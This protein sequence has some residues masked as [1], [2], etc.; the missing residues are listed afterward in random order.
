[1]KSKEKIVRDV[2]FRLVNSADYRIVIIEDINIKFLQ[3][4]IDFFKKIIAA[5]LKNKD[6]T[7]DWYKKELIK[8]DLSKEEIALHAGL[9]MKTI[10]NMYN[11]TEKQVVIDAS[12]EHYDI[13]YEKI[14]SLVKDKNDVTITL[15]IK[16]KGV[17]VDLNISESLIVINTLAVKRSSLRGGSWSA[18]GKAV[19][20][21]LMKVLC[22]LFEV[23]KKHFKQ[24]SLP[25]SMREVDFYLIGQKPSDKYRCEVKLMGKG[26][27]ESAD[28][29][30]ARNTKVFV[31]D[32]LSDL[33]KKQL[34]Q[35][36]VEWVCLRD[37]N[38]YKRFETVLKNLEIPYKSIKGDISDSLNKA[39]DK[40]GIRS[41]GK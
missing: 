25:K 22:L 7:V 32:K 19:E 23:P 2:I 35:E 13:L 18:I 12:N 36:S 16:F 1:M 29:I 37:K 28:V 20:K 31:A 15:T 34:T 33:N 6:I 39:L 8:S 10:G 4:T 3:F 9:G 11:S 27:P 14:K 26:N 21:L 5:K 40:L 24:E 41:A 30:Y 38:G 17:S